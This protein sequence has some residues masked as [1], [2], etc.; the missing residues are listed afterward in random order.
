MCSKPKSWSH[1]VLSPTQKLQTQTIEANI[2]EWNGRNTV[3]KTCKYTNAKRQY[4]KLAIRIFIYI[5]CVCVLRLK[6]II[7][8]GP[9]HI[10]IDQTRFHFGHILIGNVIH[11]ARDSVFCWPFRAVGAWSVTWRMKRRIILVPYNFEPKCLFAVNTQAVWSAKQK[12]LF[13]FFLLFWSPE[14]LLWIYHLLMA[15]G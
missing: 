1:G 13:R 9:R 14:R 3:Y 12:G 15:N 7:L 6:M 8:Q 11:I 2:S 5:S 4:A 10:R